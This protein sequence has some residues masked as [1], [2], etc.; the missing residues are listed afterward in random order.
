MAGGK[1]ERA[2]KIRIGDRL[3]AMGGKILTVAEILTGEDLE[4]I[5]IKTEKGSIRVSGGHAMWIYDESS[6]DGRRK[7]AARLK[8]GD[9]LLSPYGTFEITDISRELYNDKVYNFIFGEEE[10]ANYIEANGYWSGDFY[11]QNEEEKK[12]PVQISEKAR[13][14]MQEFKEFT[15]S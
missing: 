4:I 15:L 10:T 1:T 11:A 12:E 5:N 3:P 14:V 13:A 8:R 7:A 2:D 6:K 9:Q